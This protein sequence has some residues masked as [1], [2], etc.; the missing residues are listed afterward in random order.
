MNIVVK[1]TLQFK[2]KKIYIFAY[3]YEK[4][5]PIKDAINNRHFVQI[6]R[7][8]IGTVMSKELINYSNHSNDFSYF[9][10]KPFE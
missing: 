8:G 6:K 1:T 4:S 9:F 2:T 7:G 10:Y 5:K 3:Y